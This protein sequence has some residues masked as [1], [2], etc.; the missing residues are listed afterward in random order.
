MIEAPQDADGYLDRQA[1]GTSQMQPLAHCQTGEVDEGMRR[2]LHRLN[3]SLSPMPPASRRTQRRGRRGHGVVDK[4]RTSPLMPTP[5]QL[6]RAA[7][8]ARGC[9]KTRP[10]RC[11]DPDAVAL[12]LTSFTQDTGNAPPCSVRRAMKSSRMPSTA[13]AVSGGRKSASAF[14]QTPVARSVA[15]L[16][17]ASVQLP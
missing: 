1:V 2:K 8:Q 12:G 4:L 9:P 11:R 15:V 16:L 7:G 6:Y 10:D 17:P 14:C 13:T 5:S 3:L